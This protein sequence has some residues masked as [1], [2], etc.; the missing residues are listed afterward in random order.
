MKKVIFLT[1]ESL[2]QGTLDDNLM[3][4]PLSSLGI[5]L[6]FGDW[7]KVQS[8]KA[9]GDVYVLRS[10]WNYIHFQ[11]EFLSFC[12]MKKKLW[13]SFDV[14]RW[15]LH[16]GYLEEARR[17][18]LS[19][20][21][22]V[23]LEEYQEEQDLLEHSK[24]V[25]KPY[26]SASS[27]QTLVFNRKLP[28]EARGW[29]QDRPGD[30]FIQPF[31]ESILEEGERSF[32]FFNNGKEVVFSHAAQKRPKKGDFRVQ[33]EFGGQITALKVDEKMVAYAREFCR[34]LEKREWLYVRVDLVLFQGE[35]CLGELEAIEPDLYLRTDENAPKLFSKIL[36]ERF[37]AE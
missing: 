23:S 19:T 22:M 5:E 31:C 27:H 7:K 32:I 30:Y 12:E 11:K 37:L 1:S 9:N 4:A 16:K 35:W 15:N 25:I 24:L 34:L 17:T 33:E 28:D 26:I 14:V 2:P 21:P 20:I 10:P 18:G 13:N 3:R 29:L 36:K 8:N 6:Q